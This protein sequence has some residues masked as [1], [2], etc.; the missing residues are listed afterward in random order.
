MTRG[1]APESNGLLEY[2]GGAKKVSSFGWPDFYYAK[3][4]RKIQKA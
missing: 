1:S 3:Q 4:N 2:W